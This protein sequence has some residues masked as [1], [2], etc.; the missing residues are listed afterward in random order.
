MLWAVEF[1]G[2]YNVQVIF[3][4]LV[5]SPSPRTAGL[6]FRMVFNPHPTCFETL[7]FCVKRKETIL[8]IHT[9]VCTYTHTHTNTHTLAHK[10][11]TVLVMVDKRSFSQNDVKIA[12]IFIK[13][14]TTAGETIF[15]FAGTHT[16]CCRQNQKTILYSLMENNSHIVKM[17]D[18]SFV[19]GA[20]PVIQSFQL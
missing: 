14:H 7:V 5:H 2:V 11:K 19:Q 8:Q 13:G 6:P 17:Q 3:K 15:I 1:T 20:R 10:V 4:L 9:C 18:P 12:A 16:R